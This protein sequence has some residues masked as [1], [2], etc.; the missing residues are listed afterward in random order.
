MRGL[1]ALVLPSVLL[2]ALLSTALT[3]QV[4]VEA[5]AE[6]EVEVEVQNDAEPS[7]LM[8]GT[9]VASPKSDATTQTTPGAS[10][11]T[12]SAGSEQDDPP[13]YGALGRCESAERLV[14]SILLP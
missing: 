10:P 13:A 6:A 3:L 14:R 4:E 2:A 9:T 12:T 8:A 1:A 5:E 7:P 11:P